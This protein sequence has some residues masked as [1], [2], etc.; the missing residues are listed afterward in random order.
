[1]MLSLCATIMQ[2]V[3]LVSAPDAADETYTEAHRLTTETGRPLVVMVGTDWCGPCQA[4]KRNILPRLRERGLFKRVAFAQVN[5]DRDSELAKEITG[6]GPV[7]QLVMYRKTEKGWLRR[8]LVGGQNTET[9]ERFIQ[10]GLVLDDA[11]QKAGKDNSEEDSNTSASSTAG[12]PDEPVR[13]SDM[14]SG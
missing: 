10:E 12:V 9:V 8:K 11:E 6:G 14:Q 13:T 5:A 2:A 7:P 3:L 1:M 4:M